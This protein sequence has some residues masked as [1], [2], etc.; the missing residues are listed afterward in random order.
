M[1]WANA[2]TA[3]DWW[4]PGTTSVAPGWLCRSPATALTNSCS[5]PLIGR[6]L[7]RCLTPT[8][9]ACAK[10][11]ISPPAPAGDDPPLLRSNLA[12]SRPHTTGSSRHFPDFAA[13]Q[14]HECSACPWKSGVQKIGVEGQNDIRFR[15]IVSRLDR[16]AECQ[17]RP[18]E[19]IVTIHRLVGMPFGLRISLQKRLHLVGHAWARKMAGSACESPHP[20]RL[21]VFPASRE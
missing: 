3:G 20:A 21:S 19:H 7:R 16:L 11:P 6:H 18:F 15:K 10:L 13:W 2:C 9:K 17:L 8:A 14:S 12:C 1:A 4:S 5:S